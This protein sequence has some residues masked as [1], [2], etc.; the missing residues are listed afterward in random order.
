MLAYE[1]IFFL[2]FAVWVVSLFYPWHPSWFGAKWLVHL[3]LLLLPLWFIYESWMPREM[4]I[5]L[6]LLLIIF[7]LGVAAIMY[8]VRLSFFGVL[9]WRSRRGFQTER[10]GR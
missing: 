1:A 3:P 5:R 2:M 7:G 6:D 4:N 9:A 8:V 10:A